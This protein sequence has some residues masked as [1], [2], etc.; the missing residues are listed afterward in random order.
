MLGACSHSETGQQQLNSVMVGSDTVLPSDDANAVSEIGIELAAL[1]AP[2]QTWWSSL[3]DP[4]TSSTDWLQR[5]PVL[6]AQ[7]RTGV[8]RIEARLGPGR[9]P[10]VRNTFQPYVTQWRQMIAA[11]DRV[12]DRVA[13]GDEPGQQQAVTAYNDALAAIRALDAARV[14]RVVAVYGVDDAKR[15]LREQRLDPAEFGLG[16]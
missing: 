10:H 8:D 11:L 13:A 14:Q 12:R 2:L 7:M 4:A 16:S 6:L 15:L 1:T 9:D 5:A 3:N